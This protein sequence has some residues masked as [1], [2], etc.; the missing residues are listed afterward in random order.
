MIKAAGCCRPAVANP[1]GSLLVTPGK[2]MMPQWAIERVLRRRG[3]LHCH[4]DLTPGRTALV[5]IDM[6]NFFIGPEGASVPLSAA[7][8]VANASRII[9]N[10]NRLAQ[11]LRA[12]GGYVFW[13]K[14]TVTDVSCAQWS[15]WL[16]MATPERRAALD[17]LRPGTG[18][19]DLSPALD[20]LP[21][22]EIVLKYRYSAF[23]QGSSDLPERLAAAGIDTVVIVGA[24]T[25]VC[26]ES[27]ARDA[28]M[29]NFRTIMIDDANASVTEEEHVGAL[30]AFYASFGDVMS[31]DDF[32]GYLTGRLES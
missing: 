32:I 10:I 4:T 6:Q 1:T 3:R 18:T 23:V 13:I 30:A 21:H 28:M 5:V 19:H 12:G 27:S 17:G 24:L 2:L 31:T 7:G 9:P 25:N 22:D 11:A 16:L 20:V 15:N 8:G 29:L 26:C 14:H